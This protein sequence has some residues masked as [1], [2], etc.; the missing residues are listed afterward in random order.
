MGL[1]LDD[2]LFCQLLRSLVGK[3]KGYDLRLSFYLTTKRRRSILH[4]ILSI[5]NFALPFN[6]FFVIFLRYEFCPSLRS[7]SSKQP[8]DLLGL[9]TFVKYG[10]ESLLGFASRRMH[11]LARQASK[12]I[13]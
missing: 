4:L 8:M 5:H 9:A 2:E 11:Q 3:V 12:P 1:C 10:A 13:R 7:A 6:L